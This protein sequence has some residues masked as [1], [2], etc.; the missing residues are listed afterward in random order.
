MLKIDKP[1]SGQ[2]KET[3]DVAEKLHELV[4]ILLIDDEPNKEQLDELL[5]AIIGLVRETADGMSIPKEMRVMAGVHG[6][7]VAGAMLL[8]EAVTYPDEIPDDGHTIDPE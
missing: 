7:G 6:F 5:L 4:V 3:Y 8:D 1:E 2:R